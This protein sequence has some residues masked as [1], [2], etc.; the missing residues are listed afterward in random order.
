ME[1]M[2]AGCALLITAWAYYFVFCFLLFSVHCSL[3]A[4]NAR[5][6]RIIPK[7]GEIGPI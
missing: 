1:M 7:A 6:C 2:M 5:R 3:F 4:D